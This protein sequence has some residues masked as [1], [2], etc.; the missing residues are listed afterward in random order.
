MSMSDVEMNNETYFPLLVL[1]TK[2]GERE[3]IA[4][5]DEIPSGIPFK[6]LETRYNG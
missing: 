2:I 6:V 4:S 5:V 3:I 1:F